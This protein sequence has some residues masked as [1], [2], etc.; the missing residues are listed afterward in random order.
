MPATRFKESRYEP[1]RRA[2]RSGEP[3]E[4]ELCTVT[5]GMPQDIRSSPDGKRF[6]IADMHADGVHIVDGASFTQVGFIATGLGRTACIPAATAS[7]CMS[8]TE[9]RT[10]STDR[11]WAMGCCGDRLRHEIGSWH[12]G[13]SWRRQAPTWATSAPT[14]S[15]CGSRRAT[16]TYLPAS[17]PTVRRSHR[18]RSVPSR[19]AWTVWPQPGRLFARAHGQ[20]ALGDGGKGM[21]RLLDAFW[22]A[23]AYCLHP[24][25]SCCRWRPLLLAGG[26]TLAIGYFSGNRRWP[27]CA[28]RSKGW[29]LIDALLTWLEGLGGSGRAH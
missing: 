18:S 1:R 24:R 28:P 20:S 7:A 25:V 19:M 15:T 9:A 22:R 2:A 4:T 10:R 16:T 17:T 13:A 11:A 23:A 14:A 27:A 3:G 12:A 6:Y 26:M 5:K 8:P 21:N 29:A